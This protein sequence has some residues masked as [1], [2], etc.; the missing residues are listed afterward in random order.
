MDPKAPRRGFSFF[1]L[2]VPL[3]A[4]CALDSTPRIR[5]VDARPKGDRTVGVALSRELSSFA[6]RT[7]HDIL[8]IT[9]I[10]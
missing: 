4:T 3:R 8:V 9:R 5:K 7:Q 1:S 2:S 6:S 10:S